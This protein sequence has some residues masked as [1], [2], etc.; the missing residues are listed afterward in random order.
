MKLLTK[1]P[2]RLALAYFT[3]PHILVISDRDSSVFSQCM[4]RNQK[5]RTKWRQTIYKHT[6]VTTNTERRWTNEQLQQNVK[7]DGKC[8]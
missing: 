3:M 4:Q 1:P 7:K 6:G 2:T 8:N 5:E